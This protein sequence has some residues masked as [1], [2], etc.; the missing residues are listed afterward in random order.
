VS[1]TG[2]DAQTLGMTVRGDATLTGGTELA[3]IVEIPE[4]TPSPAMQT[5]LRA[6]VP[7]TVDVTAL[8]RLALRTRFQ[9]NLDTGSAAL[10][11]FQARV[12]GGDLTA[13]IEAIPGPRGNVIRGSATTSNFPSDALVKAFA[14][15]LPPNLTASEVGIVAV[16]A[17]FELDP[18]ADTLNVE[19]F[20]LEMFGLR[21][22]GTVTGRGIS[23]AATWTGHAQ[24]TQFSPQALLQRFGLPP[25]PTSDPE[26]FTR[27]TVDTRFTVTKDRADLTNTV[28]E[29]DQTRISG[30]FSIVGFERPAYRFALDVNDVDADRYLPPKRR[31]ADAGEATAGDIELP[32]NNTMNLD[33]TMSVGRLKLAG[34]QFQDVAGAIKI[35]D[36]DMKLQDLRTRLY[37]G[38]FNGSFNVRAAGNQPGLALDGR[39]E[40]LD[41]APLISALTAEPANFSGTGSFDL[42]LAGSGRTVI[43]NVETAAGN[44]SFNMANG[45]IKG[46]NL[47]HALCKAY[48]FTQ[49]APAP[50]DQPA[51]TA[52]V[53][54]KGTAAV[55]GGT[56]Q[57]EDLLARTSFMDVAGKGSLQLVEQELNYDFDATL[58]NP[59]AITNCNTLDRFVGGSLPFEIEGTVT[60]PS[61]TPD[62]SRLV[63][64]QLQD[65]L[66]D[67]LKD[68]LRDLL[69]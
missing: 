6:F 53:A 61:I 44:V 42:D 65:K 47:G 67:R 20:G 12:L 38:T 66:E 50:P 52:Y 27:A 4:F 25:Q 69:R 34:M 30:T 46:F 41:L 16:G 48:N 17:R 1:V 51:E 32:Q 45:A 49:R 5:W 60:A 10:G 64:Q 56:A 19:Q 39:A 24:V 9:T 14:A 13:G 7:P 31:D 23:Q 11:G 15:M 18:A 59:I 28:L 29:L 8:D 57:S 2:L 21:A 37:G 33:G 62:F 3:G 68:R 40:N 55:T 43:Q 58:T 36:G 26:A 35:A 22:V 54:I 63:Q